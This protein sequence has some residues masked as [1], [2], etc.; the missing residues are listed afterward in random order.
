MPRPPCSLITCV[1][2][3]VMMPIAQWN[4][5]LVGNLEPE[6]ARLGKANVM[7]LGRSAAAYEA[8]FISDEGKVSLIADALLL[9]KSQLTRRLRLVG[10]I[11]LSFAV[12]L[13]R[14]LLMEDHL[15]R[16]RGAVGLSI[17]LPLDIRPAAGEGPHP[18]LEGRSN[19]PHRF[20]VAA[21]CR[22][23]EDS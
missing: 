14:K 2:Q 19:Q 16:P 18:F 23:R 13:A 12:A 5:E 1:M 11:V 17:A 22:S 21:L 15:T 7:G 3:R 4:G 10:S 8:R 20:T 9:W 6:R